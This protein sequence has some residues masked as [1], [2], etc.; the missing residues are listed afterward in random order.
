VAHFGAEYVIVNKL[1][2]NHINYPTLPA[3]LCGLTAEKT[4]LTA[5]LPSHFHRTHVL[6]KGNYKLGKSK[7]YFVIYQIIN[8]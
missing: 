2:L 7:K 8:S 6:D 3:T 1:V 5:E 4:V